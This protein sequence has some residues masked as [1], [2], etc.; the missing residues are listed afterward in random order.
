VHILEKKKNL[1]S[2]LPINETRK[3]RAKSTQKKEKGDITRNIIEKKT[4]LKKNR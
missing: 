1:S 2:K 3:R 4:S